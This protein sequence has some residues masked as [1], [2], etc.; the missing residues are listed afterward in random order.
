MGRVLGTPR[1]LGLAGINVSSAKVTS[2]GD[3]EKVFLVIII[4]IFTSKRK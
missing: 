1:L 3:H 4:S 2:I